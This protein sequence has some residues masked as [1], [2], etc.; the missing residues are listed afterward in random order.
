[1]T[2]RWVLRNVRGRPERLVFVLLS[3]L[4]LGGCVRFPSMGQAPRLY[5]LSPNIAAPS[6]SRQPVSWQ[7][8]VDLPA[9]PAA[10]DTDR[11]A[12]RPNPMQIEYYG[13]AR[14]SDPVPKMLQRLLIKG[15]EQSGR[16]VGVGPSGMGLRADYELQSE[17]WSFTADY[18]RGGGPPTARVRLI[19][20]VMR[21]ADGRIIAMRSFAASVRAEGD[22][23]KGVAEAF[24]RALGQVIDAV[25]PWVLAVPRSPFPA[26]SQ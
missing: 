1:M 15:F 22:T 20:K 16:I 7:L 26:Q 11:I 21:E 12:I 2:S 10:L 6:A 18:R 9:A 5:T 4:W 24:D 19:A 23:M 13:H 3:A 8:V 14:W 25:V 17:L